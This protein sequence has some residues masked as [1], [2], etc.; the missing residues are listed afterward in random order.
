MQAFDRRSL[1]AIK[2]SEMKGDS[3]E[4]VSLASEVSSP[5]STS[6]AA[7]ERKVTR[8][9]ILL[10]K[11]L[12]MFLLFLGLCAALAIYFLKFNHKPVSIVP[13]LSEQVSFIPLQRFEWNERS[14]FQDW[15]EHTFRNRSFY[16]VEADEHGEKML[17][18]SSSATSSALFK[19]VNIKLS[20][21]PFLSWEW[22]VKQFPSHKKNQ[23][24]AVARE[25]DFAARIYVTFKGRTPLTADVIQYVWDDHFPEGTST[26]SPF[27]KKAKVLVIQSGAPTS[28]GEWILEKRDLVKDYQMLF[29]K[30]PRGNVTAIGFMSDSDNTASTS[31]AYFRRVSILKPQV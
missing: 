18:A 23:V 14:L 1:P 31:E 9:N 8:K 21:R 19:Q 25:N 2:S 10:E 13:L 11:W 16:Q 28:S 5:I 12:L 22:R 24:F 17:H 30:S 6:P 26:N 7:F 27:S 29:G 20:D 3:T 4:E 15:K